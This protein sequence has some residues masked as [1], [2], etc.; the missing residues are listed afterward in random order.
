MKGRFVLRFSS[1]LVDRPLTYLLV[2]RFDIRLNIL[3]GVITPGREGE[4]LIEMEAGDEAIREGLEFLENEGVVVSPIDRRISW[5][6]EDCVHCGACASTC[7][8]GA[9]VLNRE[10]W[11]LEFDAD[12]CVACGLCTRTCP[13]GLFSLDFAL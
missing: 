7:P 4:L 6:E 11:L 2:K 13:L 3:R 1:D 8:S 10:S 5:K 9:I 12:L